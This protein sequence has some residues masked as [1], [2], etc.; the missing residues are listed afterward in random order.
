M[1]IVMVSAE[2]NPL[3]KVGGLG[4]VVFSLSKAFAKSHHEV[5]ILLPY[6]KAIRENKHFSFNI[7]T[8]F[9]VQLGWRHHHV[10]VL[11]ATIEG[12]HF[13]A[14]DIPYY[15][16]RDGIY[17][18]ADEQERW[19]IFVKALRIGLP[20]MM[21]KPDVIHLHDWH[22]GMLPV[23]IKTLESQHTFYQDCKFVLTIHSPAFKGEVNPQLLEEFYDLP[24]MMYDEGHVRF[25]G[26]VSTLKA[27][28]V[29]SD[30]ITTVSPTHAKELLTAEGGFGLDSIL[31]ARQDHFF[32]I[33]NGIDEQEWHPF[34]NKHLDY[35]IHWN[36]IK[37]D[38][39][40]N[41]QLL[42]KKLGLRE[43]NYPLFSLISRLTFQ[44]G[45]DLVL[46]NLD[47]FIQK[48]ANFIVIGAG[49]P[50]LEARL[51]IAQHRYP[52]AFSLHL[53]YFSD[54]AHQVYAS[55]DF[56]LMP[57]LFEPCGISQMIALRFATLPIVRETGGLIDTV[58]GYS[59]YGLKAN[60]ISFQHYSG[61]A[62][63][64]ALEQAMMIYED[65]KTL[66]ILQ[67]NAYLSQHDWRVSSQAYLQLYKTLFV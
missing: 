30:A 38:K 23:T 21:E 26:Y 28:I 65:D 44:K 19:A 52:H 62:L 13:F 5:S 9:T 4:D 6:Y 22:A 63:G 17:G 14:L 67:K 58:L 12:V 40:K 33:L 11:K 61:D 20:Q 31:K 47:Y 50:E 27:A 46:D 35:P 29:Y 54:F 16:D 32:G 24:Q 64:W 15:F 34:Q 41:K 57:S 18:Y 49:E 36:S 53:G 8:S 51:K 37:Q 59:H 2:S 48:G 7:I 43:G 55:S 42:I 66:S 56:F 60:G 39:Q 45:I 25:D 10:D 3:V 1:K